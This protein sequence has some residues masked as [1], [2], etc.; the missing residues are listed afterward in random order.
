MLLNAFIVSALIFASR[1]AAAAEP[2]RHDLHHPKTSQPNHHK[3]E[4]HHRYPNHH[5]HGTGEALQRQYQQQPA[6]SQSH[7]ALVG[8]IVGGIE[9]VV[10][11]ASE[12]SADARPHDGKQDRRLAN[13]R[14]FARHPT[15]ADTTLQYYYKLPDGNFRLHDG[16]ILTSQ[17]PPQYH[18]VDV[19]LLNRSRLRYHGGLVDLDLLHR[20][21]APEPEP[22]AYATTGDLIRA[23]P[24]VSADGLLPLLKPPTALKARQFIT[25]S[26]NIEEAP[27]QHK[28]KDK[29]NGHTPKANN[30]NNG[31]RHHNSNTHGK[32]KQT[33]KP[34]SKPKPSKKPQPG[35]KSS[36]QQF[37]AKAAENSSTSPSPS[38]PD[39]AASSNLAATSNTSP[40]QDSTTTARPTDTTTTTAQ[41]VVPASQLR[42]PLADRDLAHKRRD[43]PELPNHFFKF[44][45]LNPRHGKSKDDNEHTDKKD[46]SHS[47][48]KAQSPSPSPTT[49]SDISSS[50]TET[51][52]TASMTTTDG[53]APSDSTALGMLNDDGFFLHG[54]RQG[55]IHVS[56]IFGNAGVHSAATVDD[57]STSTS[58]S[59]SDTMLMTSS[60]TTADSMSTSVTA[61]A[62]ATTAS[63]PHTGNLIDLS[64]N[65]HKRE[66]A[67]GLP[68][69]QVLK[70]LN[71]VVDNTALQS[72]AVKVTSPAPLALT[73]LVPTSPT[74][75][76]SLSA[77]NAAS[78]RPVD[79]KQRSG[80]S[81]SMRMS[82]APAP[83]ANIVNVVGKPADGRRPAIIEP[84]AATAV[85]G[86]LRKPDPALPAVGPGSI[87]EEVISQ[88]A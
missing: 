81:P 20:E 44:F 31:S 24:E 86:Q 38:P 84:Y 13:S 21:P 25:E 36:G 58:T 7:D 62:A 15:D 75:T 6:F 77:T 73:S 17:P 56:A 80:S 48:A 10:L 11:G 33:S 88:I 41:P 67:A 87:V 65:I 68:Q 71:G 18:L 5:Q 26:R 57:S 55:A 59:L 53:P 39:S 66:A 78:S 69:E 32:P 19:E 52:S 3:H 40:A 42:D 76:E 46:N 83:V 28:D 12:T 85:V 70:V 43:M 72:T 9:R 51:T 74:A 63:P 30:H 14:L 49:F 22:E 60:A 50:T 34:K 79:E 2:E 23:K 45:K 27:V 37:G 4:Q 35:H 47:H 1:V 82:S 29:D 54:L 64:L 8:S 61:S 16:T